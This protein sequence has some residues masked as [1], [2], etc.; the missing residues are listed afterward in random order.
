MVVSL[1]AKTTGRGFTAI[2]YNAVS[3]GHP[4][5]DAIAVKLTTIGVVP[6]LLR[7]TG[8]IEAEV[9]ESDPALQL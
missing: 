8:L 1:P 7:D 5:M 4:F 6:L 9:P 3:P 2:G